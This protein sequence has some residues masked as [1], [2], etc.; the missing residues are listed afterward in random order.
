M[1]SDFMWHVF[2]S[3]CTMVDI[4]QT[5]GGS[6]RAGV[7]AWRPW[8]I[9]KIPITHQESHRGSGFAIAHVPAG[10][11]HPVMVSTAVVHRIQG[12]TCWGAWGFHPSQKNARK[13]LVVSDFRQLPSP[14]FYRVPN[15]TVT[16]AVA[17][18]NEAAGCYPSRAHRTRE[19]PSEPFVVSDLTGI[20]YLPNG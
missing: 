3:R 19:L 8:D 2:P 14:N 13:F 11:Y 18:I 16:P 5:A 10:H 12:A 17:T 1:V 7:D 9:P 6:V 15:S 4:Y 20:T